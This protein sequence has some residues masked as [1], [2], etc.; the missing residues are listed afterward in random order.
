MKIKS[1][2]LDFW[3]GILLVW[4]CLLVYFVIIPREVQSEIQRGMAPNFFPKLSVIWVGAF[5]LFLLVKSLFPR[6]GNDQSQ[7]SMFERRLGRKGVVFTISLSILYL[8][9]CSLISFVISTILALA[10]LMWTMG[11]RRWYIIVPATLMTT[12][13]IYIIFGWLMSVQLPEGIL[14]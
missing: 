3:I 4:V 8:V 1:V 14:F 5:S 13:G 11:E 10:I 6:T 12:F 2:A 7:E 9:L